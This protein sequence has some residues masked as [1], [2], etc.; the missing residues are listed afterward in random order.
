M[1]NIAHSTISQMY[2]EG[3][4]Q[5]Q[6]D[7]DFIRKTV[8]MLSGLDFYRI[9]LTPDLG[10]NVACLHNFIENDNQCNTQ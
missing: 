6:L 10:A 8:A 4:K 7:S 2:K 9:V 1:P 3:F 5:D